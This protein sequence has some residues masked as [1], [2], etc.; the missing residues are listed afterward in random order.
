MPFAILVALAPSLAWR[1][2]AQ[3]ASQ[4]QS[5]AQTQAKG[6]ATTATPSHFVCPGCLRPISPDADHCPGCG[7][8]LKKLEYECPKCHTT[9]SWDTTKCPKCGL[10]FDPPAPGTTEKRSAADRSMPNTRDFLSDNDDDAPDKKG[11]EVHGFSLTTWRTGDEVTNDGRESISRFIEQ[12]NV[13][14]LHIYV[15]ELSF[16]FEGL[17]LR[18]PNFGPGNKAQF[19]LQEA[20]LRYETLDASTEVNVGRQYVNCGVTREFIDAIFV[21]QMFGDRLGVELFGGVP[22]DTDYSSP[23]GNMEAGGRLFWRGVPKVAS[24]Y[25]R[26]LTLSFS[27]REELWVSRIVREDLGFDF[28]LSPTWDTDLSGHAYYSLVAK[29]VYDARAT[30][31]W[32]AASWFQFTADYRYYVPSAML[33]ADSIF[34]AFANGETHEFELDADFWPSE[35]LKLRGYARIYYT[36]NAAFT[37]SVSSTYINIGSDAPYEFGGGASYKYGEIVKLETGLEAGLLE[38]GGLEQNEGATTEEAN[39]LQFRIYQMASYDVA[40]QHTIKGTLDFHIEAN[41]GKVYQSQN[42]STTITLTATYMYDHKYSF[43]LGGD[44]RS[45]PN[46]SNTYD[47]FAKLEVPF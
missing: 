13:E 46:F 39:M 20:Y 30:F 10:A 44:Y 31:E 32:R 45:T 14:I 16:H 29:C 1:A 26:D 22:V 21:H 27:F 24:D 40:L 18:D 17:L 4:G 11:L 9:I 34:L 41:D 19:M 2:H 6:G 35:R 8:S 25:L 15:P 37:T 7:L 42:T 12:L 33:P 3:D 36:P 43:T 38:K 47:V 5:Q 23:E 28:S